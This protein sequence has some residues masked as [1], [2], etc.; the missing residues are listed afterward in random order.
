MLASTRQVVACSFVIASLSGAMNCPAQQWTPWSSLGAPTS[1]IASEVQVTRFLYG[2]LALFMIGGDGA[3]YQRRQIYQLDSNR[4]KLCSSGADNE[5]WNPWASIGHPPGVTLQSL[6]RAAV[7]ADGR[8]EVFATG[9]DGKLWHAWQN[10]SSLPDFSDWASL[11]LPAD[12]W[13]VAQLEVASNQDG[14]LEVFVK[15]GVHG[16]VLH[17]WQAAPNVNWV[18][19]WED[20][21]FPTGGYA[22]FRVAKDQRGRLVIVAVQG[23]H[24]VSI[25]QQG[26]NADFGSWITLPGKSPDGIGTS[27]SVLANEDGRLEAFF[28]SDHSVAHTWQMTDGSWSG[29]WDVLPTPPDFR[30]A[31]VATRL[32]SGRLAVVVAS[33]NR[34]VSEVL[35]QAPNSGWGSWAPITSQPQII[36]TGTHTLS[37]GF[38]DDGRTEL[39]IVGAP[40]VGGAGGAVWR[41]SEQQLQYIVSPR[42]QNRASPSYILRLVDGSGSEPFPNPSRVPSFSQPCNNICRNNVWLT[43]APPTYPPFEWTEIIHDDQTESE[44]V[45]LSGWAF[46]AHPPGDDVWF[47][48]PFGN[49]LNHDVIP[50]SAYQGTI[51]TRQKCDGD[52]M[53]AIQEARQAGFDANDALHVEIDSTFIPGTH[54][55]QDDAF[56]GVRNGD[57]VAE[58]GRWITDCGHD[59]FHSEIHPPLVTVAA[60]QNAAGGTHALVY[61]R[62]FLVDQDFGDGALFNHLFVGQVFKAAFLPGT[63]LDASPRLLPQPFKGN[64]T[65]SYLLR[66]AVPRAAPTDRLMVS[67]ALSLRPGIS[68]AMHPIDDGVRVDITLNERGYLVPQEPPATLVMI[69]QTQ[70]KNA[71]GEAGDFLQT[72]QYLGG[73]NALLN[74]GGGVRT[75]TFAMPAQP[76]PFVFAATPGSPSNAANNLPISTAES[77]V[78]ADCAQLKTCANGNSPDTSPWPIFG[79]IDLNWNRIPVTVHVVVKDVTVNAAQEWFD[80]GIDVGAGDSVTIQASGSWSN[81]EQPARGGG[82]RPGPLTGPDGFGG[83]FLNGTLLPSAPLGALVA[84]VGGSVF[85][86]GASFQGAAPAAGRL[87]LSMNDVAG[88]FSDNHGSLAVHITVVP[89]GR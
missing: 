31:I 13:N 56:L 36:F 86:V 61:S 59:D 51:A 69:S 21:G 18:S 29:S 88:T 24:A 14:R 35:Q 4:K 8:V 68:V 87:M 66:P 33:Q 27:L 47:T 79:S 2:K 78:I 80:T 85:L 82:V 54:D 63:V 84:R 65:F 50:D 74:F 71:N 77:V 45:A 43:G 25:Q 1:A 67:Y 75:R 81:S 53:A 32:A 34:P 58:V 46:N 39:F 55:L 9:S 42:V 48:H 28:S 64:H 49:D 10:D 15:D 83:D 37:S 23:D 22:D 38:N 20:L 62:P 40:G 72:L 12:P 60:R 30:T 17:I 41:G 89:A 26:P 19:Q 70:I 44:E 16:H 73:I 5:K 11:P 6:V 76:P 57:R 52:Q 7:N 3:V